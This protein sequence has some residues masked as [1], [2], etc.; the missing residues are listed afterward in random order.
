M[1]ESTDDVS[2]FL[3]QMCNRTSAEG[4]CDEFNST[5]ASRLYAV[6]FAWARLNLITPRTTTAFGRRLSAAGIHR[7]HTQAGNRYRV[8]PVVREDA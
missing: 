6:Y 2:R 8:I 3:A 1:T 7:D 4:G 5:L